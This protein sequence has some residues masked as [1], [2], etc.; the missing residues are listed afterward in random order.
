M[1]RSSTRIASL[2]VPLCLYI[3]VMGYVYL[4]DPSNWTALQTWAIGLTGVV[5]IWYTWETRELRH[6]AYAQIDL[7][8]RPYVV[9][10]PLAGSF[11]L[12]N[13]G[14]GVALHIR[15]DPVVV[16]KEHEIE[17]RFPK[18]I[19]VLRKGESATLEARSYKKGKDAG[20]FFNAHLDPE[21]ANQ[22]TDVKVRFDDVELKT[23]STTQRVSPGSVVVAAVA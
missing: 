8:I 19:P 1:T 12:T 20:D 10:Q 11:Q 13:F 3:G 18:A 4:C 7:Q 16:S 2:L 21:H 22:E 23:Y 17:I 9:L 6:A 14:N 5:I 15:V